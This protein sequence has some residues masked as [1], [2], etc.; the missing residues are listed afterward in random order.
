M[1]VPEISDEQRRAALAKAA[2]VRHGRAELR[3]KIKLGQVSLAEVL[4]S[5]D[6]AASGMKVAMLLRSLPGFGK[7]KAAKVMNEL[8]IAPNRRVQ[9]LGRDQRQ[10]LMRAVGAEPEQ[11]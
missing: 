9:G 4:A 1:S 3:S 6:R 10:R 8:R 2:E 11:E 5:E 7:A